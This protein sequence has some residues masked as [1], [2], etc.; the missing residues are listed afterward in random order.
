ME[1]ISNEE[2]QGGWKN[3]MDYTEEKGKLNWDKKTGKNE[4]PDNI[5]CE[6]SMKI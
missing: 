6:C 5:Q 3:Y 1:K 2:V 4:A